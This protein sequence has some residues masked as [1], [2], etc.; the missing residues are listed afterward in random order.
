MLAANYHNWLATVVKG[1][2]EGKLAAPK[3]LQGY[4]VALCYIQPLTKVRAVYSFLIWGN[5]WQWHSW[6][7]YILID[8]K[9]AESSTL[10]VL[11]QVW[12]FIA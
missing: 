5:S 6:E 3:S 9:S 2:H 1:T 11:V 7:W 8:F 4:D 10:S 12:I